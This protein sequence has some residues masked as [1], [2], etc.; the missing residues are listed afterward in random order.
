MKFLFWAYLARSVAVRKEGLLSRDRKL[1]LLLADAR[2]KL[3]RI[4]LQR[5]KN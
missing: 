1:I 4:V 2:V 3:A 5:M